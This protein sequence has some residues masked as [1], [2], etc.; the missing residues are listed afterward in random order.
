[1]D[2][3]NVDDF[4]P[5]YASD[6]L[7][8]VWEKRVASAG[9][10]RPEAPLVRNILDE[11]VPASEVDYWIGLDRSDMEYRGL[12]DL[13][14]PGEDNYILATIPTTMLEAVKGHSQFLTEVA[15]SP[16]SPWADVLFTRLNQEKVTAYG[17]QNSKV[18]NYDHLVS[19]IRSCKEGR[20]PWWIVLPR[21]WET[22]LAF[23]GL[24]TSRSLRHISTSL[25]NPKF[26][27]AEDEAKEYELRLKSWSDGWD[28]DGPVPPMPEHY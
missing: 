21:D 16:D 14:V 2:K 1:M 8:A 6:N 19:L 24:V 7:R 25:G 9:S 20:T 27:S 28:G 17:K 3:L 23:A 13:C 22:D 4:L 26:L 12:D 5:E 10:V 18:F 11:A 15:T